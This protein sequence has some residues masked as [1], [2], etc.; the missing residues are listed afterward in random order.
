ML[1]GADGDHVSDW[2][3][4]RRRRGRVRPLDPWILHVGSLAWLA[5]AVALAFFTGARAPSPWATMYALPRFQ[6]GI[7]RRGATGT[8]LGWAGLGDS[9]ETIALAS[10]A[11]LGT[12]VLVVV[13]ALVRLRQPTVTLCVAIAFVGPL[14]AFLFHVVGYPDVT[15]VLLGMAALAARPVPAKV[16]LLVLALYVHEIA[17]VTLGPLVLGEVWRTRGTRPAVLAVGAVGLGFLPIL[18]FPEIGADAVRALEARAEAVLGPAVRWDFLVVYDTGLVETLRFWEPRAFLWTLA[19]MGPLLATAVYVAARVEGR[20]VALVVALTVAAPLG[21]TSVAWDVSRWFF[22]AG[23]AAT[24]HLCRIV[25]GPDAGAWSR[26]AAALALV[27]CVPFELW[28]FDGASPRQPYEFRAREF[29]S[30]M[31]DGSLLV[32]EAGYVTRDATGRD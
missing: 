32:P 18:L 12:L 17:L 31:L 19:W 16:A 24:Y 29:A 7:H 26:T 3:R 13:V 11:V 5:V 14:G 27:W 1:I 15:L 22:F 10:W 28:M 23:V 2:A 30:D 6:D 25:A 9:Y 21:L 4:R 8:I 20:A